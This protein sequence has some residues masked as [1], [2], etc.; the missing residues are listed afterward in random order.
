MTENTSREGE[1]EGE[2]TSGDLAP[3]PASDSEARAPDGAPDLPDTPALPTAAATT[4][5][6]EEP[7]AAGRATGRG[8]GVAVLA[9]IVAL[10]A[11]AFAGWVWWQQRTE[12]GRIG[13]VQSALGDARDAIQSALGAVSALGNDIDALR[14]R[15]GQLDGAQS[16][17]GDQVAADVNRLAAE[18]EA[19][20]R[21]IEQVERAVTETGGLV[22]RARDDWMIAETEYL[23]QTA[24][25]ALQMARDPDA[26]I[27]ALEAADDR[28][29]SLAD[30]ALTEIRQ[31]L[32]AE[33]AALRAMPRPDLPGI[34]LSLGSLAAR[35]ELL[36][37][38]GGPQQQRYGEDQ[39]GE[40]QGSGLARARSAV[41]NAL[42]SMFSIQRD[43]SEIAP[44]LAPDERFFLFRNLA[45]QIDAARL[46][47]LRGDQANFEQSLASARRWLQQHFDVEDAGVESALA[48]L[49][50][51]SGV[52]IDPP[53]PDISGSLRALRRSQRGAQR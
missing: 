29:Q 52:Q 27:A 36:P 4:P 19:A 12:L 2:T 47:A 5:P 43:D 48:T 35:V 15:V 38:A 49:D 26:A 45:L 40:A 8:G 14:D 21:T 11:V 25:T 41:S 39:K 34:A 31:A 37:T 23:L 42:R 1:P 33:L 32:A 22:T 53:E 46:A 20:T 6:P 24:N 44:L 18:V 13:T 28:L 17:L 7:R 9:L 3:E 50:E 10:V 51:L 16:A 30:P